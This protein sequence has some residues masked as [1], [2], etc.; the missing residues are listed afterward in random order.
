M[1]FNLKCEN[2]KN[3]LLKVINESKMPMAAI[4]FIFKSIF[5]DIQDQYYKTIN[6]LILVQQNKEEKEENEN[7]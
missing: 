5:S 6:D 1:D 7:N 4:Y 3:N 2:L